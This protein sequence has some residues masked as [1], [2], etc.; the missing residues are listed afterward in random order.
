MDTLPSQDLQFLQV[1]MHVLGFI[2]TETD[3]Q[4]S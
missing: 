4:I 2:L 3:L 1:I